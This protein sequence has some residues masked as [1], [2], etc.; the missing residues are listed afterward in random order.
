[1]RDRKARAHRE[2]WNQTCVTRFERPVSSAMR[3]RSCE[4]GFESRAKCCCRTASCS[5]E[6]VVRMRFG[7]H[8]LRESDSDDRCSERC[9]PAPAPTPAPMPPNSLAASPAFMVG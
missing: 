7:L 5:S 3:S 1:M 8:D 4:S 9:P 6:N 2:F